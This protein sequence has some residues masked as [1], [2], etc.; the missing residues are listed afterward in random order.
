MFY[1]IL[2]N[3]LN[4]QQTYFYVV[5]QLYLSELPRIINSP[6]S[7]CN[8]AVEFLFSYIKSTR[9]LFL[10][11]LGNTKDKFHTSLIVPLCLSKYLPINIPI[12]IKIGM[13][14]INRSI[15]NFRPKKPISKVSIGTFAIV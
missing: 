5:N 11:I 15:E 1:S 13:D 4:Q 8:E 7:E 9:F 14:N 12:R 3:T 10:L 6:L 2:L